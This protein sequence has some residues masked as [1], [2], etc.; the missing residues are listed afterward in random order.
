DEG[1]VAVRMETNPA[2]CCA[3][4]SGAVRRNTQ[5]VRATEIHGDGGGSIDDEFTGRRPNSRVN[6]AFFERDS[7]PVAACLYQ[8]NARARVHFNVA[9]FRDGNRG[10]RA[11]ICDKYLTDF[12]PAFCSRSAD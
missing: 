2:E 6:R 12:Q 11:A 1:V 10:A 8:T 4:K 9:D 7:L 3:E 5:S